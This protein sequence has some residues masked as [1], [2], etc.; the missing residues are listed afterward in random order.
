MKTLSHIFLLRMLIFVIILNPSIAQ[1]KNTSETIPLTPPNNSAEVFGEAI[2]TCTVDIS[3]SGD[4]LLCQ[5]DLVN[6]DGDISGDYLEFEWTSDLGY[7]NSSDLDPNVFVDQTETFTLCAKA[8]DD[9]NLISN[10]DFEGGFS[11]FSSDYVFN[12][13]TGVNG[14]AQGS[15]NIDSQVPALWANQCSAIDGN[16]MVVNGDLNGGTNAYCTD[17]DLCTD[18]DY[19]FSAEFMTINSPAPE[20]QFSINGDLLGN[21]VSGG[22]PC[23]IIQFEE[24]WNSESNTSATIC[25]VNQNTAASGNDFALDNIVFYEV[26]ASKESFTVTV[27]DVGFFIDAPL[28]ISCDNPQVTVTAFANNPNNNFTYSWNTID[29][30]IEGFNDEES[31][32]VSAAG[33]YYVTVSN[34]G[35]CTS[36]DFIEVVG[37][38]DIPT[39]DISLSNPINCLNTMAD[40]TAI[41][42]A[43]NVEFYWENEIGDFFGFSDEINITEAGTYFVT[44]TDSDNNCTN[45]TQIDVM[46]DDAVPIFDLESSN[47]INCVNSTS[48]LTTSNNFNQVTWFTVA[49]N[50]PLNQTNDTITV[51][52][53]GMYIAF[54][55]GTNGC[56]YSDTV[57]VLEV[58]TNFQ[59]SATA[60]DIDCNN[61]TSN[62]N[63]NIDPAS[64]TITWLG[65][66]AQNGSNTNISVSSPGS[67]SYIVSDNNGCTEVANIQ[68]TGIPI[69]FQYSSSASDIDCNNAT[70]NINVNLDP[71][72]FTIN[73]IGNVS[74]NGSN[75]SISVDAPGT[76][77]FIVT[78]NNGCTEE[79]SVEVIEIP[80]SVQAL[81]SNGTDITCT[82]EGILIVEDPL[83]I[84][85]SVEWIFPDGT[86][87][88]STTN[89]INT[90]QAGWTYFQAFGQDG[91]SYSDSIFIDRVGSFPE[92]SIEGD[93]LN[94]NN[95]E[96]TL[97]PTVD[98]QV[99]FTW[100]YPDGNIGTDSLLMS[101]QAGPHTLEV[102]NSDGCTTTTTYEIIA[103]LMEPQ[104]LPI[105]DIVLNCSVDFVELNSPTSNGETIEWIGPNLSSLDTT[106]IVSE[107]GQYMLTATGDN[108]CTSSESFLVSMDTLP[109]VFNLSPSIILDCDINSFPA[110]VEMVSGVLLEI[111]WEGPS[112]EILIGPDV[113]I[114]QAGIWQVTAIAEN[115]CSTT[116]DYEVMQDVEVPDL[117]I[118]GTI[119]N[120][121]NPESIITVTSTANL[122]SIEYEQ[123][124]INIG[125]GNMVT[126]TNSDPLTIVV[127][128]ENGCSFSQNY[129]PISDLEPIEFSLS[130]EG[131][132]CNNA[133]V[134]IDI[135]SPNFIVE[136]SIYNSNLELIGDLTTLISEPGIY[137]VLAVGENGC[138][139]ALDIELF[140]D[141]SVVDFT[142]EDLNLDCNMLSGPITINATSQYVSAMLLDINGTEISAAT[143]TEDLMVSDAGSY[144]VVL[145]GANGCTSEYDI[146]VS[147]DDAS[148]VFNLA[149]ANLDCN[150]TEVPISIESSDPFSS[151]TLLDVDGQLID[152]S[153]FDGSFP[154]IEQGGVYEVIVTGF[155]GCTSIQEIEILQDT[156]SIDLT[157][158]GGF[159]N[160]NNEPVPLQ[161]MTDQPYNQAWVIE[162]STQEQTDLQDSLFEINEVGIYEVTVIGDNGCL[163]TE[164]IEFVANPN[165]LSAFIEPQAEV[166]PNVDHLLT[167]EINKPI[168]EIESIVW[169][170][171][172]GLSC[173][174]CLTPIFNGVE[175]TTYE[176]TVT[177]IFGCQTI[178]FTSVNLMIDIYIPNVF[179][180][181]ES[182][183]N[184]GF[185]VFTNEN[186]IDQISSMRIYDRWGN[187]VFLNE[188][189]SHNDPDQGWKG[190][191][192]YDNQ[193][194]LPGVYAYYI[195]VKRLSGEEDVFVGDVTFLR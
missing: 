78:D 154:S 162:T 182:G 128:D 118:D 165:D 82:N 127:I 61:P 106:I 111:T 108:G 29:G 172:I 131:L 42:N 122:T 67:Y 5:E 141:D 191:Y 142:A 102:I 92:V 1:A 2:A 57:Q 124:N 55:T 48:I 103:D 180:L 69:D 170:P 169:E 26:C 152:T 79:N 32:T 181:D 119:I 137:T 81:Q 166:S 134:V 101:D 139:N 159:I 184:R 21:S 46:V 183:P 58:P 135:D 3:V 195:V 194:A 75:T 90:T 123:N 85:D 164:T 109:P 104:L 100:I 173:D 115:G 130:S 121:N 4:V 38:T 65:D 84:L 86:Q 89:M 95:G 64:F 23:S 27:E 158:Q 114:N 12:S 73:W 133:E 136:A 35:N 6:L 148:P 15:F 176:I 157:L 178:I 16:M 44:V 160:C 24:L 10:G 8:V 40:L 11:D 39:V 18:T 167:L 145:I 36:V 76:Y 156:T 147:I 116:V 105:N 96:V 97:I 45:E 66:A 193:M 175:S 174:D 28:Q 99:T 155:N 47:N 153:P 94:C 161:V 70:S 83:L 43:N 125:S 77:S 72:L 98:D 126:V 52:E 68:V 177:D 150:T 113:T 59:Y 91:C 107:E 14:L 71:T 87:T 185:T 190:D 50:T 93:I 186:G 49:N 179:G 13:N 30:I 120:C 192:A 62:I 74:S 63:V 80:T 56:T 53:A 22:G 188:N 25:I 112:G 31:I 143:A 54:V 163:T 51:S 149:S 144:T 17:V 19:L 117:S 110:S 33:E 129:S 7:S 151:A 9:T 140:L 37:N 189:F 132:N 138:E 171:S 187:L 34:G 88:T 168:E 146:M 41:T 20:L 60:T